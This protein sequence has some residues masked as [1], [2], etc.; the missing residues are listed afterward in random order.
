MDGESLGGEGL[1]FF[2]VGTLTSFFLFHT[3]GAKKEGQPAWGMMKFAYASDLEA[4]TG[5]EVR[6]VVHI[7]HWLWSALLLVLIFW[8]FEIRG[9][10]AAGGGVEKKKSEG[11]APVGVS[12]L[13]FLDLRA[14]TTLVYGLL[15]GG[16][17]HGLKFND[18]YKI[19]YSEACDS[20]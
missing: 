17:L 3:L 10:A 5:R 2:L 12:E 16:V 15:V 18:W 20:H 13:G 4:R 11:R 1:G 6:R 14:L 8:F 7:H 19:A 9:A